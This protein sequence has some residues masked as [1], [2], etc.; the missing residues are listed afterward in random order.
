MH[1]TAGR[2]AS[3]PTNDRNSRRWTTLAGLELELL[4]VSMLALI[5]SLFDQ[6]LSTE[7]ARAEAIRQSEERFAPG[8]KCIN[9][10]AVVA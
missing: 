8:A 4:L 10:I 5:A 3:Q 2:S 6:R 1:Y 7:T 9:I